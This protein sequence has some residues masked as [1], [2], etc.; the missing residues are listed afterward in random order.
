[1][2]EAPEKENRAPR[3]KRQKTIKI[4]TTVIDSLEAREY[5]PLETM[6]LL[7]KAS[8][9]NEKI[10]QLIRALTEE[11]KVPGKQKFRRVPVDRVNIYKRWRQHKE[12]QPARNWDMRGRAPVLDLQVGLPRVRQRGPRRN[13][14]VRSKR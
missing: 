6:E 3:Q 2:P 12:G 1:L 14:T 13:F 4:A 7:D 5:G 10:A 9:K 11:I 8:D